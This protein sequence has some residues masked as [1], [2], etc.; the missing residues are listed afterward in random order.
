VLDF[1]K[2]FFLH[3]VEMIMCFFF[4]F[5]SLICYI[6]LIFLINYVNSRYIQGI[7]LL[8]HVVQFFKYAVEFVFASILQRHPTPVFLPGKS[9]GWRSLVQSVGSLRFRHD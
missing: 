4:P 9:H 8:C 5:I 3:L 6:T 7:I 1:V 2:F